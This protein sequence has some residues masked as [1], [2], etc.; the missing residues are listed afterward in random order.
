M[1]RN[2]LATVY[3]AKFGSEFGKHEQKYREAEEKARQAKVGMWAQ[4][5]IISRL[6]KGER[7]ASPETPR[8][9]KTRMAEKGKT[10]TEK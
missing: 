8:A 2:G 4:P 10:E 9:F 6:L 1:I 7:G 3:E 5:G